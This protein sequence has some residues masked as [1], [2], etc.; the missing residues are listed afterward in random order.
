ME[1]QKNI[2]HIV[3]LVSPYSTLLDMCGPMDVFQK[4]IEN[5]DKTG[6]PV[7]F[8]YQLHV[9]STNR[10]K[11]IP[12][13]AGLSIH[14]EGSYKKISYP[15]DAL[16]V[17]GRSPRKEYLPEVA[18]LNWLKEQAGKVRR[19]CSV[20]AGAFVL[21]D[22]GILCNKKQLRIGCFA[23]IWHKPIRI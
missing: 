22:A 11:T 17:A 3:I 15:I 23:N 1:T 10:I 21:A 20:C 16:I 2:R 9:V 18:L 14:S 12:M 4:A 6:Q 8:T 5:M 19:I 13:S 7:N